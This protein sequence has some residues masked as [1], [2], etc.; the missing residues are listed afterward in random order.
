MPAVGTILGDS[1]WLTAALALAGGLVIGYL[2]SQLRAQRELR[3]LSI[4]KTRLETEL[5]ADQQHFEEQLGLLHDARDALSHQFAQLAREALGKNSGLFLRL[6]E[7]S[8]KAQHAQ[9]NHEL[10]QRQQAIERV[11][12]P[13]RATL[14]RTEQRLREVEQDRASAQGQLSQQLSALAQAEAQ[15]S[16][17]T[18]NLIGALK[19]A[20]V[21]GRWGELTLR[22]LAEL[23]G[24]VEHCDFYEQETT[25]GDA[26]LRPDMVV[27]MPDQRE[28]VIDAKAVLEGYLAAEE[29]SDETTRRDALARHARNLRERVRALAAKAYWAQFRHSPDFVVLFVPGE[30]FLSSAL[31][32]DPDLLE[33]ALR[34]R[35]ILASPASLVAL[36]RA[37]AFGWRQSAF[38]RNA[39]QIRELGEELYRRVATLTEHL[40]QLG[41][42]LEASVG[43]FNRTLGALERQVTPAARRMSELGIQPRKDLATPDPVDSLPRAPQ[44]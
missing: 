41:K 25:G 39:E 4:E 31:Q 22:R 32:Q 3:Q 14:E 21:R 15:L 19:R 27:R 29:A 40:Q 43:A 17:E 10:L 5:A 2:A 24:M 20:D 8:L 34:Q 44:G 7:Q 12:D 38:A 28:L 36:L 9:A 30:Q 13:I 35:V 6:A 26:T 1:G 16:R 23:S 37:V 11:L 18:Q 42:G 33:D